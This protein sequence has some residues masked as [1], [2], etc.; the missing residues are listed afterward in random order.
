MSEDCIFC[1][2]VDGEV[3]SHDVYED[4][5]VLAFL[6]VNPVAEGHAL[7][8]PKT[9]HERL[10]DMDAETTA[11]VFNAARE[12]AEAMEDA[13]D[14]DGYNLF[15]TNGAAAGQEVFHSH[16]HVVPRAE[17]DDVGFEFEPGDLDDERA[18]Q[19]RTEIGDAL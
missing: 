5:Q 14:P 16:V 3:P 19:I 10:T 17:G 9:H 1:G 13:L 4:D 11:A 8:I 7:V 12:V 15:Q 6:D 18:E 2:I